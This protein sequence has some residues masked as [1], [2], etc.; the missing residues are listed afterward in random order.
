MKPGEIIAGRFEIVSFVGEGGMGAVY[1]ALDRQTGEQVALKHV[2]S[3]GDIEPQTLLREAR[4]LLSLSHPAI[5]RYVAHGLSQ[6][7]EPYLAMEWLEGQ[8]L[9]ERLVG[10]PMSV[11]DVVVLAR[12]VSGA[13][14]HAH[15]RGIVH[16]DL[17][18]ANLMLVDG[19]M[20]NVKVLD[21][22]LARHRADRSETT[23]PARGAMGTLGYM[24]P[25]QARGSKDVDA[26]A[27]LFALGS[28]LFECLT[29]SP[30][31]GADNYLAV[32]AKIVVAGAPRVRELVP[33]APAELDELVAQL[34]AKDPDDRP[35]AADAVLEKL[36][37]I[38]GSRPSLSA[39]SG[40]A[41]LALTSRERV[42]ASVVVA[43]S[44][45]SI[46]LEP[47]ARAV[48]DR[49]E[50]R[51]ERLADGSLVASSTGAEAARDQASRL[52]SCALELGSVLDEP[53]IA[54]ATGWALLT[55][56]RPEGEVIERAVSLS[57]RAAA[58]QV[59]IDDVTVGLLSTRF[60]VRADDIGLVLV[61]ERDEAEPARL[62]L[63]RGTACVGRDRELRTLH[64]LID[65][66][67]DAPLA[68]AVL[69]IGPAGI[70]K[71]RI[72]HELTTQLAERHP[73][74]QVWLGRG[75]PMRS[76]S[77]LAILTRAVRH[78]LGL[79]EAESPELQ[80][81]K[82]AARVARHVP[83]RERE[84][85]TDFVAELLGVADDQNASVR[86]G[87]ARQDSV[88]MGDQLRAALVDL[89]AAELAAHPLLLV[90]ED[91]QWGDVA[92]TN[93]LNAALRQLAET[94]LTVLAIGRPDV[95][96]LFPG[97][98][99]EREVQE[100]R[101]GA[102]T[103]RAA[104]SLVKE[105]LP[106]VD[107]VTLGRIVQHA[108]G[109]AFYL[110]ELI[111]ARTEGRGDDL[112]ETVLAMLEDRLESMEPEARRILRAASVYGQ[113]FWPSATAALLG[114][115]SI[116]EEVSEWLSTLE[117]REVVSRRLEANV[118]TEVEYAFRHS[119]IRDAAYAMLTD[120]DRTLGHRLAAEWLLGAGLRDSSTL[121][122][123][124]ERG[125]AAREAAEWWYHAASDA[126]DAN[127]FEAALSRAERGARHAES[128]EE[129][130]RIEL[131]RAE[132]LRL[133]GDPALAAGAVERAA[134]NAA[135]GGSIWCAALGERALIFQR[136]GLRERLESSARELE[137]VVPSPD[138][139]DALSLAR[140]RTALALLRVGSRAH[141]VK[142]VKAAA[143]RQSLLGP[144][145]MAYVHAFRA[146]EALLEGNPSRYL[147][148]AES[149]IAHHEAVGN[150]RSA[151]EQRI[152]MGSVYLELG[153]FSLAER[154]LR[155]ALATAERIG[156]PHAIAGAEHNLG[157][158]LAHTGQ[159]EEAIRLETRALGAFQKIDRRLEGGAELALAMISRLGRDW[160]GAAE[161]AVAA[162]RLLEQAAPPLVPAAL[163]TL[164]AI[165]LEQGRVDEA[166]GLAE[167]AHLELAKPASVEYGEH[168]IRWSYAEALRR[169]GRGAEAARVAQEGKARLLEESEKLEDE[170][171]RNGFLRGVPDNARLL[172]LAESLCE[173]V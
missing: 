143:E 80:R 86:L 10:E 139:S 71:S 17:N 135:R 111:R 150:A 13:L 85:I 60:E 11:E 160:D 20:E 98:W 21:F 51:L 146:V 120:E 76:G 113:S 83:E 165:R 45:S 92:S 121:A 155:D 128:S 3:T 94:P 133:G 170:E 124:F 70:G 117:Q 118:G 40:D 48:A 82:L 27:D 39:P 2:R 110:E 23:A 100:V 68:Q 106:D 172:G 7:S 38:G 140:V 119:L 55:E 152:N 158:A 156:L 138:A 61:R 109:N 53:A 37:T 1:R 84:R 16:R 157:L 154:T 30:A 127:D 26:R 9:R 131:A 33:S 95:H 65:E 141:A 89:L 42:L 58:G 97:L 32:L 8:T 137:S 43:R 14:A 151:L 75:D 166:L 57:G 161:H 47:R 22:G 66:G 162:L 59:R 149:A 81:R 91:L 144:L 108:A 50:M 15:A 49:H 29:G 99:A 96:E 129:I 164:A 148:E 31:F 36:S 104:E 54:L 132:A 103:R 112:P 44:P 93:L 107:D 5:V 122:E 105:A 90:L 136:L 153:A 77:S 73:E 67:V 123:H 4:A 101:V 18:P 130:A 167:Q 25:E 125:G 87:A 41:A 173:A 142:L 79:G 63:G 19:R 6:T 78:G 56:G 114:G 35:H 64:A 24:A 88:L 28:V 116:L 171:L 102:L 12:R 62:L 115:D 169:V 74:M 52:A 46:A 163:G 34:L 69:L 145:T 147:A 168:L 159:L 126:L 134:A 72:R